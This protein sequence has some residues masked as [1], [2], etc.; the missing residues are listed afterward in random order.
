V[1]LADALEDFKRINISLAD[2]DIAKVNYL[3]KEYPEYMQVAAGK[4]G[5]LIA[6]AR[7][8]AMNK[9]Y[10]DARKIA[11]LLEYNRLNAGQ[12]PQRNTCKHVAD[13]VAVRRIFDDE[14]RFQKLTEKFAHYQGS[15]DKN[16]INC[17]LCH[18]HLL[19]VHERLQ[20]QAFLNPKEKSI[21]EKEIILKFSGGQFQGNYICR[22]CGQA[23]RALDFD[24]NI[25][26]D[27]DG[28][29]K[30]GRALLEDK[31]AQFVEKIENMINVPLDA[32]LDIESTMNYDQKTIY[33]I[34]REITERVGI[35]LMK[36]GYL[37]IIDQV[38][39][40]LNKLRKQRDYEEIRAN[41]PKLKLPLYK[42]YRS[43]RTLSSIAVYLL[44]E[45][46]TRIPSYML[47]YPL[48]GCASPGFDG[49]PLSLETTKKQGIE[50]IACAISSI[51]RNDAPWNETGYQTIASDVERQKRIIASMDVVL[52]EVVAD[53]EIQYKLTQKRNYLVNVIGSD[54]EKG[55]PK[56]VIPSTF[57]PKQVIITPEDAARDAIQPEV[58]ANMGP[59]GRAALVTLWIRQS[60][61]LAKQTAS[62]VRDSQFLNTTCCLT[63]IKQPSNFWDQVANLPPIGKRA[64]TPYQQGQFLITHFLPRE[65]GSFVAEP[66][67]ESYFR[68]FLTCCF[69]GPRKGYA[70]EPGLDNMCAWC[71]FQ[72]PTLPSVMDSDTE[73]KSALVSQNI[74]TDSASFTSLLDQIHIV[75][76]VPAIPIKK[77][78]PMD[79]IMKEFSMISPPPIP[80]WSTIS[81]PPI[82]IW[83]TILET[84]YQNFSALPPDAMEGDIALAAA[85]ISDIAKKAKN[86]VQRN[87]KDDYNNILDRIVKLPWI[88]FF[89]VVETY[90]ITLFERKVV[91]Y[92][93]K[94]LFV[95]YEL[96]HDLSDAHVEDAIEP[97]I[98]KELELLKFKQE[99]FKEEKYNFART[100]MAHYVNQLSAILPFKNKLNMH[101]IP[102]G[103]RVQEFIQEIIFYAPMAT[104]L[105]NSQLA[106]TSKQRPI[107][108]PSEK[109]IRELL[110]STLFKFNNEYIA[111][112]DK[113]IKEMIEIRNEKERTM[114]LDRLNK[115]SDEEKQVELITKNLRMGKWSI[116]G[117]IHAYDGEI[118][119]IEQQQRRE[120]GIIDFPDWVAGELTEPKGMPMD[121]YGN[122][123]FSDEYM[124]KEGGYDMNQHAYEDQE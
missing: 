70:H 3:F 63:N 51:R 4:D 97:I 108:D 116:G 21:L 15:R 34:I 71:G 37:S 18:E 12:K 107:N 68:I 100:K 120:M 53:S 1:R 35:N 101:K 23:I 56:D 20:I 123:M 115:M 22:N 118:W 6:K 33:N 89:Q 64:L 45:I 110:A 117:R 88:N 113:K 122:M 48:V 104:L 47:R 61:A 62:L 55:R 66:E 59:K 9:Q 87:F 109:F 90:F 2:S 91:N 112:D 52:R 42:E 79:E 41:N 103:D 10:M 36:D 24:N 92:N 8:A 49:Y 46:Q 99:D 54:P 26:F 40:Y 65:G 43:T 121:E 111:Y 86:F 29:P 58:V 11:M 39:I 82:P 5:V 14:E 69:D 94:S 16:W 81:P 74:N 50:Y 114:V 32:S 31:D 75:N 85:D 124:E 57:L 73:G 83:S 44:L 7:L 84:T 27:D 25:E 102:S 96:K 13:F 60:H 106:P 105:D 76:K 77:V 98:R 119:E 28:K 95:P 78:K 67:K 17:N 80:I 38:T 72:F 30:S 93:P 19:C